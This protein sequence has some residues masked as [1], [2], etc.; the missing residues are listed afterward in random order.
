[1]PGLDYVEKLKHTLKSVLTLWWCYMI[2][3]YYFVLRLHTLFA[4]LL[5]MNSS[6]N[7]Y[8]MILV[9]VV[10]ARAVKQYVLRTIFNNVA[11]LSVH[12][13]VHVQYGRMMVVSV[14]TRAQRGRLCHCVSHSFAPWPLSH[15][16]VYL[17]PCVHTC[18]FWCKWPVLVRPDRSLHA[19][20]CDW[21]ACI[22]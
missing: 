18:T 2:L 14:D 13:H 10:K 8:A 22:L 4:L 19:H 1:M 20:T 11:V 6:W 7:P 3:D 21:N 16:L 17:S 15:L 9:H 12:I 5:L